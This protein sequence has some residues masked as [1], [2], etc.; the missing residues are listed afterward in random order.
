MANHVG[1]GLVIKL[2]N[3]AELPLV[4]NPAGIK[5]MFGDPRSDHS[6]RS[7]CANGVIPTLPR[8]QGSGAHHRIPVARY[9]DRLGVPYE[10][11]QLEPAS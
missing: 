11:V 3:G 5:E 4:T 7:D 1:P 8:A 2:A 10:V 9:L 6:I